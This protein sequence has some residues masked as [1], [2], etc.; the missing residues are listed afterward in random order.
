MPAGTGDAEAPPPSPGCSEGAA[1]GDSDA[2][3]AEDA[4]A[5]GEAEA[6]EEA[7]GPEEAV[8]AD[9]LPELWQPDNPSDKA[10]VSSRVPLLSARLWNIWNKASTTF[11]RCM[12][13][14]PFHR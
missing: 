5:P 4:E 3:G 11:S 12:N 14:S 10:I 2:P 9:G 13:R 1:D 8:P 7:E 6:V